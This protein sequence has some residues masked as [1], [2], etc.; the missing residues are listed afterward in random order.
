MRFLRKLFN[1]YINSSIHVALS[2]FSL[3][4]ITL[5]SFDLSYTES[6]LYFV[7]YASITGY[8][9]VKYFAIAKFHHRQ[10]ANWLKF[11][12]ILSFVCFILMCFYAA[13]LT[14]KALTFIVLLMLLTFFYAI[15]FFSKSQTLRTIGGLKV[16]IIA[17]VWV[18]VTVFLPLITLD[19]KINLDVIIL[20]IQRFL[21]VIALML[22]FEIRDLKFDSNE[23]STIPQ[24]LGLKKTKLLGLLILMSL[25]FLEF[26]KDSTAENH[27]LVMF[28]VALITGLLVQFSKVEQNKYYSSFWVE[29]I[30]I[31]WLMLILIF[32]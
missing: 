7:F 2:V 18:S 30:P 19:Y 14:L 17:L 31:L 8:N 23:L 15:P 28:I 4:W 26:F 11:I 22:P 1:F 9:F 24:K 20:G 25:F 5:L 13:Q 32:N 21:L 6:V 27:I 10:L 29:G 16:Y 12:Q 3:A